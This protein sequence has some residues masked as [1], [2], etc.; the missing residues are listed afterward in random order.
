MKRLL[1]L[2]L[3]MGMVGCGGGGGD[4]APT[5]PDANATVEKPL[6]VA[7]PVGDPIANS[8]GM[9]LVPIPAGE[10]LMGSPESDNASSDE[11]PQHQVTLTKPFLLGVHEVT[12]G[13]WQAVMGTTPWKG[14]QYVKEGD[15]YPATYVNWDDA[16]E[17]CRQLSEKEGLE[18]RLPTEAEWE[19]ACRAGTTTAY[20]FGADAS[21]LGEYA[22]CS[23]NTGDAG[24]RYAHAV[25]QKKPNPWGLYDM[26]GNLWEWCSDW[27]EDY[28]SGSVTD[29]V[30]PSSGSLRL[31]RG[32]GWN[33]VAGSCRSAVR[34]KYAP[35][36]RNKHSGFRVALS[37]SGQADAATSRPD[38]ATVKQALT[39]AQVA[40]AD[41][42]VELEKLGAKIKRNDNGEVVNV[43]LTNTKISDAA[44]V[45]LKRLAKLQAVY[46]S[47]T[48]ITDAGLVHLKEMANLK[49]LLL[50]NTQTTDAGLEHLKG[51]TKLQALYINGAN[52]TDAGLVNLKGLTE[53]RILNLNGTQVTDAGLM[54]LKE[55]RNLQTLSLWSTPVSDAGLIHLKGLTN[56]QN[57]QLLETRITDAGLVHFKGLT[58]L[59][60]L[61]LSF[62]QV[63]DA[64]VAELQKALPNCKIKK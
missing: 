18:F 12:Q 19:Y 36:S 57:L 54:H 22:W 23:E 55:M 40:D 42:V 3:V 58:N 14:K 29:P 64:G 50:E 43:T 53:L 33:G 56:L 49:S 41:P 24:Q 37:P 60:K 11:K 1:G 5:Q 8:I 21:Q 6:E 47:G 2:L 48:N 31:G 17:F 27:Y 7:K 9:V 20:S 44:L 62:T 25:G 16:V 34:S 59:Q 30:G 52:I 63:T 46:I 51:L 45:R 32:G 13:Q 10:F 15:D 4:D 26:H 28:P 61:H 35:S 39:P 38:A